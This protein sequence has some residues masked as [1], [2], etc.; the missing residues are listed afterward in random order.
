MSRFGGE[1]FARA[2]NNAKEALDQS[3]MDLASTL[4]DV[5]WWGP[6]VPYE[7]MNFM[8][9]LITDWAD[10]ANQASDIRD[11]EAGI[12]EGLRIRKETGDWLPWFD[13]KSQDAASVPFGTPEGDMRG[14]V[15]PFNPKSPRYWYKE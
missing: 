5:G 4:R 2:M 3:V 8:Q 9:R 7:K 14:S 15:R 10:S 6:V 12:Q 13:S 1:K 11:N